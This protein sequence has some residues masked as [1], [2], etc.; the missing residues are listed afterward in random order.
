MDLILC[1]LCTDFAK[2]LDLAY[3]IFTETKN[4]YYKTVL[5]FMT[6]GIPDNGKLPED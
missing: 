6:D 5:Y 1:L 3:D 4:D 2:P